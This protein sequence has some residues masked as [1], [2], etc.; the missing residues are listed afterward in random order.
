VAKGG[1]RLPGTTEMRLY[2]EAALPPLWR[3]DGGRTL[4]VGTLDRNDAHEHGA[5]VFLS[6]LGA[7]FGLRL[8]GDDRWLLVD[9]AMIPAG[10]VHELNIGGAPIAVLYAEPTIAG[11]D[12]LAALI[13]DGEER[14]GAVVGRSKV[15][16]LVRDLYE[17]SAS[18]GWA[19]EALDDLLGFGGRTGRRALDPRVAAAAQ[20]LG[21]SDDATLTLADVAPRVNLSASRLRRLFEAEIGVPFGRYRAWTRMRRALEAVTRG[22]NLTAAAHAAGFSDQAHFAHDFR[23]TFGAPA[24]RSLTGVR[25]Q[26]PRP[27]ASRQAPPHKA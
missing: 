12:A 1:R 10:I 21:M 17:D 13:S 25:R 14:T 26:A 27:P 18:L 24:S 22:D 5:P 3:L 23:R 6:S 11:A 20:L 16:R 8:Q 19:N 15:R 9:A 7:P 2:E 4:F